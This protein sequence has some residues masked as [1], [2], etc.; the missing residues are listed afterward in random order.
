MTGIS[1]M[2]GRWSAVLATPFPTSTPHFIDDHPG[3]HAVNEHGWL[4]IP[5]MKQSY[6]SIEN[7]RNSINSFRSYLRGY[8][9]R[10]RPPVAVM[11]PRS[12]SNHT[13]QSEPH[14][15]T[16][17][18]KNIACWHHQLII[19]IFIQSASYSIRQLISSHHKMASPAP[20]NPGTAESSKAQAADNQ[21]SVVQPVAASL[22]NEELTVVSCACKTGLVEI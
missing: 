20:P 22:D 18:P 19:F 13:Q 2:R 12:S 6:G 16:S 9:A 14:Q 17:P 8:H 1:G 21:T 5:S 3:S 15:T 7:E 10:T 4:D 11:L